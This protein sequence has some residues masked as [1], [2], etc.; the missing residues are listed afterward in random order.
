VFAKKGVEFCAR[1]ICLQNVDEIDPYTSEDLAD[2]ESSDY[3]LRTVLDWSSKQT[4]NPVN[5]NNL[6]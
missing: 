1:K 3:F 6:V 4:K 2:L 5:Q